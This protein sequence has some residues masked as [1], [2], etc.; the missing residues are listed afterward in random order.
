MNRAPMRLAKIVSIAM[1]VSQVPSFVFTGANA[2]PEYPPSIQAPVENEPII[3][4]VPPR[5]NVDVVAVPVAQADYVPQV[6]D[7]APVS[8]ASAGLS[9]A[10]TLTAPTRPVEVTSNLILGG[11]KRSEIEDTPIAKVNS[12]RGNAE[13]QVVADVPT[14]LEVTR[15][16]AGA[17]ARIQVVG[18]RNRIIPL[19]TLRVNSKGELE[20]PPLTK[21]DEGKVTELRIVIGG[22]TYTY[23]IRAIG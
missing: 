9:A 21:S 14:R 23:F 4:P 10:R 18:A 1:L 20:L 22:R 17:S 5:R 12:R 8:T 19:G 2:A 15:L 6:R 16:P 3:A 13:I 7:V 11:V